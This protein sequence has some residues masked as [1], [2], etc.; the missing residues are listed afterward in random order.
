MQ[1]ASVHTKDLGMGPSEVYIFQRG[2]SM[3]WMLVLAKHVEVEASSPWWP[4]T[5]DDE[6]LLLDGLTDL[7]ESRPLNRKCLNGWLHWQNET[8][9]STEKLFKTPMD[10]H[11]KQKCR[12]GSIP[13]LVAK[14]TAVDKGTIQGEELWSWHFQCWSFHHFPWFFLCL[15]GSNLPLVLW[16]PLG[17]SALCFFACEEAEATTAKWAIEVCVTR[18]FEDGA[19]V[20]MREVDVRAD[21]E[22][23]GMTLRA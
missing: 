7:Q 8:E 3:T 2:E 16:S 6:A 21:A 17:L 12:P 1:H 11:Q 9:I 5:W 4:C 10:H 13:S 14:G 18:D 22:V 19:W 20:V 15:W 23:N